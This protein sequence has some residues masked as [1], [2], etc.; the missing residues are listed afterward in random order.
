MI[1]KEAM[2]FLIIGI[3]DL[4]WLFVIL[5]IKFDGTIVFLTVSDRPN[6]LSLFS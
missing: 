4:Q 3:S 1:I 6:M 5:N 2:S